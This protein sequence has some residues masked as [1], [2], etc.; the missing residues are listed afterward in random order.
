[1]IFM[2]HFR[3]TNSKLI[4]IVRNRIR[5][6]LTSLLK[7][8]RQ[9]SQCGVIFNH[10]NR[11]TNRVNEKVTYCCNEEFVIDFELAYKF[12]FLLVL[13]HSSSKWNSV[14][15]EYRTAQCLSICRSVMNENTRVKYTR[16]KITVCGSTKIISILCKSLFELDIYH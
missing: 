1:M 12:L 5:A 8:F 13:F 6:M 2:Q 14:D 4:R 16:T 3:K 7:Y 10:Y 15:P 9:H 11:I